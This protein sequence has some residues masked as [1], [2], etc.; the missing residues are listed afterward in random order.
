M[1]KRA[2]I[3]NLP[4]SLKLVVLGAV[5]LVSLLFVF[6][7]G[8]VIAIPFWG[9][10]ILENLDQLAD[11]V[12]PQMINL[13]KYLQVVSQFGLFI[14]PAILFSFLVSRKAAKYL[15]LHL[16]ISSITFILTVTLVFV[17]VPFINWLL[18]LN[19]QMQLPEFMAGIE[20]W[21][22]NSEEDA[23][24]ITE[25]FLDVKTF[26]GLLFNIFMIA[27]IPAIGEE[28][29]FRGLLQRLVQ[30]WSKNPHVAIFVAGFVFSFIHLQFYGFLPRMFLGVMFGYLLY[31][32]GSLWVPI[33]AHFVNN[34]M[35]VIAYY[36]YNKGLVEY[37][38]AEIDENANLLPSGMFSLL[39]IG[40][41]L[42][43][44]YTYEQKRKSKTIIDT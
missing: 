41:L 16:K 23:A 28:L 4:P 32:T 40:L 2:I 36:F 35:A 26:G 5:I 1:E 12:D 17:C 19:Y 44:I 6:V 15:K 34:A 10:A 22:K 7:L 8:M 27:I 25:K 21:M 38:I 11:P 14:V 37:N 31:W 33:L 3:A 30:E 39:L 43:W 18:Q 29:I 13:S 24:R 42:F 20:Q 9:S